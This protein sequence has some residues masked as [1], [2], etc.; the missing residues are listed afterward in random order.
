M[1]CSVDRVTLAAVVVHVAAVLALAAVIVAGQPWRVVIAAV[2]L[3]AASVGWLVTL[4]ALAVAA[5]EARPLVA[6]G[7][8]SALRPAA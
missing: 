5:E 1:G 6:P 2:V 8:P 7:E 4:R 3:V